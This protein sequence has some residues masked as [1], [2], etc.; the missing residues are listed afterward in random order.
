MA[1]VRRATA[2]RRGRPPIEP[3]QRKRNNVTVRVRDETKGQL[4]A[5]AV[6]NGRSLSEEI[7]ARI[8]ESFLSETAMRKRLEVEFGSAHSYA[9]AKVIAFV[10]TEIE[11]TTNARW[12][13]DRHTFDQL[14]I[15]IQTVLK[16]I[17]TPTTVVAPR[18][19]RE[20]GS[21]SSRHLFR[22]GRGYAL[23]LLDEVELSG[24]DD[25][26]ES[27]QVSRI[28]RLASEL[29]PT[30]RPLLMRTPK[31]GGVRYVR[32]MVKVEPK[33]RRKK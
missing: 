13:D 26:S 28:R 33:P 17:E 21:P 19:S 31:I 3:S 29:S 5:A 27:G 6:L 7:E 14:G 30:L 22:L 12:F 10:A 20:A 18:S 24:S 1:G 2:R 15:A 8:E 11:E 9:L 25:G 4:A 16:R 32:G 23:G